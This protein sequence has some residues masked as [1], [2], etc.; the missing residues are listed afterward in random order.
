MN[1]VH[2]AVGALI[3]TIILFSLGLTQFINKSNPSLNDATAAAVQIYSGKGVCSGTYIDDPILSDGVQTTI[4]TAKHCIESEL[5]FAAVDDYVLGR[6]LDPETKPFHVQSVSKDSDLALLQSNDWV[7]TGPTA[8]IYDGVVSTGTPAYAVGYPLG[9]GLMVS[10]GTFWNLII[11][12]VGALSGPDQNNEFRLVNAMVSPGNSG[13]GVYVLTS[14]GYELAG[15]ATAIIGNPAGSHI[16]LW[17]DVSEIKSY[18][19][20]VK[21]KFGN[22]EKL[23]GTTQQK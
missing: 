5:I 4:L 1:I 16:S 3:V 15:S 9:V 6:D 13:G 17:T 18:L 2:K 10:E 8:L 14:R 21:T 22:G 12:P 11:I 7:R 20:R 19:A 23:V